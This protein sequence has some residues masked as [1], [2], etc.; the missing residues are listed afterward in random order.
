MSGK[1]HGITTRSSRDGLE[2]S[3][4]TLAF[5]SCSHEAE[6][7]SDRVC[8][9]ANVLVAELTT[10]PRVSMFS[11]SCKGLTYIL[12]KKHIFR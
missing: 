9:E 11:V 12:L 3:L 10:A 8:R 5:S 7:F 1:E 2:V 4:I 6:V